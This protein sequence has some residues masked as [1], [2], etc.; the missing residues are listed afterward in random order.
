MDFIFNPYFKTLLLVLVLTGCAGEKTFHE[1]ARAGDTVAVAAGYQHYFTRDNITVTL[2]PDGGSPVV[3]P[4]NDPALRGSINMYPDPLASMMVSRETAQDLT[5]FAQT[6]AQTT[7][8][9]FTGRNK[10]WWQ[11]VVF[12]D[13]PTTIPTG[14]LTVEIT[15]PEG[16][17]AWS[18][19]EVIPGTGSP[20]TFTAYGSTE[21]LTNHIKAMER[22]PHYEISFSRATDGSLPY[23]IEASFTHD[24]DVDNGGVGRAHVVNPRAEF[25]ALMWNDDGI[26]TRVIM[27]A[28]RGIPI[29]HEKDFNF[30]VA[31]GITNL[32]LVTVKAYDIDG[33]ELTGVT[34]TITPRSGV[35]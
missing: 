14:M 13:L 16:E 15:N 8:A 2:T 28:T 18:T 9:V 27:I 20:N 6:Y 35:T 24:A 10:D 23:A 19:L 26:N 1:Y 22:V 12:I 11:T 21:L 34:A 33:N 17:Y 3:I 30:Y 7:S 5:I 4:A 32:S 29:D 25:K 31:G